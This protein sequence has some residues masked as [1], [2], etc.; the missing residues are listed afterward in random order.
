MPHATGTAEIVTEQDGSRSITYQEGQWSMHDNFFGGE[1]YG[2]RQIV[3]YREESVW[4]CVYYGR[5][6]NIDPAPDIYAFLREALA[7]AGEDALYRGPALYTNQGMEYR[8]EFTGTIDHFQGTEQITRDGVQ[9]YEA[10]FIGG[11]VDQRAKGS[12]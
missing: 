12:L 3:H 1:P 10:A 2:G 9:I 11:L 6:T 5:V 7:H 4:L 8:N